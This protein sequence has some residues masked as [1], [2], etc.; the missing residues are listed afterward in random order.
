M[1][2]NAIKTLVA[3]AAVLLFMGGTLFAQTG[4][5]I[6]PDAVAAP[7]D[8][9]TIPENFVMPTDPSLGVVPDDVTSYGVY[10]KAPIWAKTAFPNEKAAPVPTE[11]INDVPSYWLRNV[12]FYTDPNG[13][14]FSVKYLTEGGKWDTYPAPPANLNDADE[15]EAYRV[16]IEQWNADNN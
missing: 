2:A 13:N 3:F 5:G 12:V 1:K 7:S 9:M 14:E 6:S 10:I 4:T 15:R 11:E 8:A 16:A